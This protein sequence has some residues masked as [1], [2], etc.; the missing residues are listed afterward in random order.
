MAE[1]YSPLFGFDP[2]ATTVVGNYSKVAEAQGDIA[3]AAAKSKSQQAPFNFLGVG[4][5]VTDL[6]TG[7]ANEKN[8]V[9]AHTAKLRATEFMQNNEHLTGHELA[10][11]I[12][13]EIK[14][15][16]EGDNYS[17]GYREGAMSVFDVGYKQALARKEE[18][19]V[20]STLNVVSSNFSTV[21]ASNKANGIPM[22]G[23]FAQSWANNTAASLKLPVEYVRNAMVGAYYQD[24]QMR[25][26]TARNKQELAEA[27]AYIADAAK[28]LR[29]PLFLD[30]R[31]KKFQPVLNSMKSGLD[32]SITAKRKEFKDQAALFIEQK[33]EGA[34]TNVWD[35]FP[36]NPAS[37]QGM[38]AEAYESPAAALNAYKE[39]MKAFTEAEAGR[40]YLGSYDIMAIKDAPVPDS[41]ENKYIKPEVTKAVTD[42]LVKYQGNPDAFIKIVTR[43]PDVIGDAGDQIIRTFMVNDDPATL[44]QIKESFD[45]LSAFPGGS[46]AMQLAFG[47]DY[48]DIM[49]VSVFADVL[50]NGDVQKAKAAYFEANGAL[51]Q[52]S[53]APDLKDKMFSYKEKLGTM[54]DEF[55]Y[56]VNALANTNQGI[57]NKKM[58]E[59]L[60]ERFSG[61]LQEREGVTFD[62]SKFDSMGSAYAPEVFSAQVVE[63]ATAMNAGIAPS[64]ITNLRGNI[65]SFTDEF[66]FPTGII[67]TTPVLTI[68]NK[69]Y[70]AQA[71]NDA[72][73]VDILSR[74]KDT[75]DSLTS[76]IAEAATTSILDTEGQLAADQK[77]YEQ[78]SVIWSESGVPLKD[79]APDILALKAMFPEVIS[80]E[81]VPDYDV[82]KNMEAQN[83]RMQGMI[84]S[85]ATKLIGRDA[86][87]VIEES[88]M[89]EAEKRAANRSQR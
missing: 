38:Y 84:E 31:S 50:T 59:R 12:E 82:R 6:T 15:I 71:R 35:T 87:K 44:A 21:L 72:A 24:G 57:V 26:A 67:N 62:V 20:A 81:A 22:T 47:D 16:S 55:Q 76:W 53:L 43:N 45:N 85:I 89:T 78:L 51:V 63:M 61:G 30:S 17:T 77:M 74:S 88:Q 1:Q 79:I 33:I 46:Q 80:P 48:R 56:V 23:D 4:K 11:K 34:G 2:T 75:V 37:Y 83:L 42:A 52:G 36:E 65:M 7:L 32:S 49:G 25:V 5:A 66:G 60:Y 18:E 70:E 29:T 54:G 69:L 27:E 58:L 68:S 86:A 3:D 40:K 28:V 19:R 39:D 41:G 13:N 73:E 8:M 10:Q 9:D 14:T 64:K